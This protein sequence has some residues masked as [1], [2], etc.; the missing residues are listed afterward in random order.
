MRGSQ[1]YKVHIQRAPSGRFRW[2]VEVRIE[3]RTLACGWARSIIQAREQ[4]RN[5]QR[6]AMVET[7]KK[8]RGQLMRI[9][10]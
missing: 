1:D 5:A 10:R 3:N 6:V 8:N 9:L 2:A 4:A 7:G